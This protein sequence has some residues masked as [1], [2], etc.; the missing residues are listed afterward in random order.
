MLKFIYT[1]KYTLHTLPE[2]VYTIVLKHKKQEKNHS[3]RIK[4][5]KKYHKKEPDGNKRLFRFSSAIPTT[6]VKVK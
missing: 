6:K 2:F 5:K 4:K 1:H 3:F